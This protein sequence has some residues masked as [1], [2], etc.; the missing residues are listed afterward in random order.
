VWG[1][2]RKLIQPIY[3]NAMA[4]RGG[5]LVGR[6]KAARRSQKSESHRCSFKIDVGHP[7]LAEQLVNLFP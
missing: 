6:V 2:A 7:F 1:I 4:V 3:G 5:N